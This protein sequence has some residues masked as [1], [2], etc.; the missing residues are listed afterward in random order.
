M[1]DSTFQSYVIG[2][3]SLGSCS[4]TDIDYMSKFY[5]MLLHELILLCEYSSF[6]YAVFYFY[7]YF[8][9]VYVPINNSSLHWFAVKVD[10]PFRHVTLYDPSNKMTRGWF[11]CRNVK[12]LAVLFLY[13]LK[14]HEYYDFHLTL[15]QDRKVN[16]LPFTISREEGPSFPQQNLR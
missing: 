3:L 11:Q 8:L 6:N 12:C 1:K 5:F 4:R 16:L 14:A 2:Q 13:L 15:M 9:Q 10:K 7:F